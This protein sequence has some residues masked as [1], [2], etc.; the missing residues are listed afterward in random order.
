MIR[1]L[2]HRAS[3]WMV[4]GRGGCAIKRFRYH[5]CD[6]FNLL[7]RFQFIPASTGGGVVDSSLLLSGSSPLSLASMRGLEDRCEMS[8][9]PVVGSVSGSGAQDATSVADRPVFCFVQI[10]ISGASERASEREVIF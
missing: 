10:M 8:V 7:F 5:F 9:P 1:C 3:S 6:P 2:C 4:R